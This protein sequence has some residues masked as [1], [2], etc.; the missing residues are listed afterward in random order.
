[1]LRRKPTKIDMKT[2]D[3][4]EEYEVLA[5]ERQSGTAPMSISDTKDRKQLSTEARIGYV[6]PQSGN[7]RR[8]QGTG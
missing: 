7:P 3:I 8:T 4:T 2:E 1:M 5:R 6:P